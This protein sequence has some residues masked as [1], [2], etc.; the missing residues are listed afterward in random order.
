MIHRR[1][2]IFSPTQLTPRTVKMP[3]E[4][5][6]LIFTDGLPDGVSDQTPEQ[7]ICDALGRGADVQ[8][9][10]AALKALIDPKFH[11][12]DVTILLLKRLA[13]TTRVPT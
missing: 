6:L 9:D 7:R 2:D 5:K 8:R 1:I 3:A 10:D 11:D 12:D 4:G 13:G